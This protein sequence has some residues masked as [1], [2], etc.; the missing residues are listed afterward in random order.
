MKGSVALKLLTPNLTSSDSAILLLLFIYFRTCA[1]FPTFALPNVISDLDVLFLLCNE[2]CV[3]YFSIRP[4]GPN[5]FVQLSL[6][7][8]AAC[9]F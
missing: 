9:E 2:W 4:E 5:Y 7:R 8:T 6:R 3:L 1:F